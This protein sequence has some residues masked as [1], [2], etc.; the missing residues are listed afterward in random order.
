[1]ASLLPTAIALATNAHGNQ[2]NKDGTLYIFHPLRLMM[3]AKTENEQIVAILHDAVEDTELTLGAIKQAGLA[4]SEDGF[5]F[6]VIDAIHRLTKRDGQSYEEY[7][8]GVAESPLA[9]AVK[10][11]DLYDNINLT[12]LATI[13]EK[14]LERAGK[15]HRSIRYLES[16]RF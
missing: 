6:E 5:D 12:R 1:M 10:L 2:M 13:T 16:I 11:L 7:L 3:K 8:E 14:D 4:A 9:T 15:Y